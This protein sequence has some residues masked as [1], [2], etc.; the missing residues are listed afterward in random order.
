MTG[1]SSISKIRKRDGRIVEFEPVKITNAI[2]KAFIAV[3]ERDGETAKNLSAQVVAIIEDTFKDRI[4]TV[5][6]VQDIVEKVLIKNGF[7]DVAKAYIL[8]RQKR[9]EIREAKKLLG[10]SDDLKLSLN[11]TQVLEKRYLLKDDHG[12]VV[13]TPSQMFHRVARTIAAADRLY[14]KDADIEKTEAV[15]YEVMSRLEFL[16]NSPTLMNAGTDIGQLSACFVLPVGDSIEEI[17]DA[18]KFMAL[19]HK[20]GGGTGFSFS[21]LRPKGDFVRSTKGVASGPVSFMRIFDTATDIIKQGGRRRGANMG[22]LRVDHP[23]ILEFISAKEKEGS[24][25]NF[26]LSVGVTDAFMEAVE[27]EGDYELINP[28]TG[29]PEKK[30]KAATV[31]NLIVASA[32]KTGDPG[33]VFLDE[34]NRHN[35]TPTIGQIESTNPCGEVPLLPYE[36]CN[37]GSI[38]LSRMVKNSDVDWD[39]LRRVVRVAVHFLDNVIDANRYPLPQ[40]EKITKENRKIGLGVMGFAELLIQLNIPYDSNEAIGVAEKVM[41]FISEEARKKSEELALERGSFPNFDVSVWKEK[42]YK[43]MR[44]ATL[45]TIA[46]T[47]SISIIAGT[48]SGIE[49]LFAISFVRNV[50][51]TQLL[52]VNHLFEKV[53]KERGFYGLELMTEIA[54]KGSIRDMGN[55]PE[56]VR[57]VFVTALDID[58]EWHVRMQAA[59]QKH[60]DNAVSKTVN[61]PQEATIE[62][63]SKIFWLA[64]KL[65]CKG[66]TVF[67]YGSKT[68]QVLVLPPTPSGVP[69]EERYVKVDSEY[70]GGCP[71]R[72][73]PL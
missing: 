9:T 12:N 56:D 68:E 55:I 54:K 59:F 71:S 35:P 64:Y 47:G 30:L 15:F 70:A 50:I 67:R 29:K 46:P 43:A 38:N 34:I 20:S 60:V 21:R 8:Y 5:E 37:L 39:K 4:P 57:R 62:D 23:D 73:C 16:P 25:T 10:V 27:K 3:K 18:L 2:H 45:T 58:P 40:I 72:I 63:V 66:I 22:I 31:F 48:S 17:F 11:A 53:A 32:W 33:M 51:G 36:S 69:P 49:P 28:R 52:E 19:I 44:N 24:L 1:K 14:D 65:K 7:S 41:S 61:L 13:E 26:N 6:E 42:G